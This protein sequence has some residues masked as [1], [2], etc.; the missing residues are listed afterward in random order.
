RIP[1][2]ASGLVADAEGTNASRDS[3]EETARSRSRI[4]TQEHDGGIQNYLA[5]ISNGEHA[6]HTAADQIDSQH[7]PVDEGDA[8]GRR[9]EDAQS[10]TARARR[11]AVRSI[12]E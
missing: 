1:N 11:P 6:G 9:V 8:D 10:A 7:W 4:A 5:V 2:E 12:D 3:R